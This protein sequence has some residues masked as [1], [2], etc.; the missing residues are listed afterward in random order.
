MTLVP[1]STLLIYTDGV[2]EA[3]DP[4]DNAFTEARLRAVLTGTQQMA[5]G[6]FVEHVVNAVE[7]FAVGAPQAD[8]LTCLALR[9]VGPPAEDGNTPA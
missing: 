9:Y 2:T 5:V 7:S 8:D 3:F 4:A 6:P 1:G